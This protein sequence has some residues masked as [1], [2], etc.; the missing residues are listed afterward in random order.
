MKPMTTEVPDNV[1]EVTLKISRA[2]DPKPTLRSILN[3]MDAPVELQVVVKFRHE[4][5]KPL[6][7]EKNIERKAAWSVFAPFGDYMI[8]ILEEGWVGELGKEVLCMTP[9]IDAASATPTM[10]N[11]SIC[12]G[13]GSHVLLTVVVDRR[14]KEGAE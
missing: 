5:D 14:P 12:L 8:S 2:T 3:T 13:S 6:C 1:D 7:G 4:Y 9:R 11:G 10:T